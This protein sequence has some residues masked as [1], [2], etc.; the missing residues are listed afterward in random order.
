MAYQYHY[1]VKLPECFG[2]GKAFDLVGLVGQDVA[3]VCSHGAGGMSEP[4][5]D[6][7]IHGR[8]GLVFVYADDVGDMW[9]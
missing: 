5:G 7:V 3:G 8:H 2:C 1:E 4:L 6:F 9:S